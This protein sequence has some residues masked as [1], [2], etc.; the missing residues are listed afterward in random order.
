V[1]WSGQSSFEAA[2]PIEIT[3]PLI[4]SNVDASLVGPPTAA[5]PVPADPAPVAKKPLLK[6]KRGFVK[7]KVRGKQRCVKRHSAKPKPR[8]KHP[9]AKPQAQAS[10]SPAKR[11]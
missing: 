6:C 11:P 5:A 9:T 8:H 4:V 3:P 7:R 1:W 10:Q 2:T